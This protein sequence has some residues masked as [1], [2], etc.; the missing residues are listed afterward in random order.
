MAAHYPSLFVTLNLSNNSLPTYLKS[1]IP[2]F[3]LPPLNWSENIKSWIPEIINPYILNGVLFL[4]SMMQ[5]FTVLLY[6]TRDTNNPLYP[7]CIYYLFVSHLA[8]M[9]IRW[10]TAVLQCLY[11]SN[12]YLVNKCYITMS[13]IHF[14]LSH[15]VG[16]ASS[17]IIL[18]RFQ[19]V[20]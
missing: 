16:I 15:H 5:C 9:V 8:L 7:H 13:V 12:P 3:L 1:H 2:W 17:Q 19:R 14:D 18:R 20:H 10:T 11:S 4:G 6:P